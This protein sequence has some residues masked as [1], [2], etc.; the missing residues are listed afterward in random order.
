MW[1]NVPRAE[2]GVDP[3]YQLVDGP[4]VP[5]TRDGGATVRRLAGDGGAVT[6]MRPA[7]YRDV[8]VIA[9]V[10][11]TIDVPDEWQGFAYVID[12]GGQ[13]GSE[14]EV[15]GPSHLGI[16]GTTG[17]LRVAAGPGGVRFML[18]AALPIGEAPRWRG[19]Y[20]D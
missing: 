2:K 19:P 20:V 3:R 11:V 9:D 15:L 1:I 18:G 16:L 5:V 6:F 4:A 13:F 12:G 10:E 17:A 7:F 14:A 8:T